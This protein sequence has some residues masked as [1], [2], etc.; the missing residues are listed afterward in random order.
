MIH[1]TQT[2]AERSPHSSDRHISPWIFR[3]LGR[4]KNRLVSEG[5]TPAI[6]LYEE[7]E[8]YCVA[9]DLA[10]MQAEQIN[11]QVE[12]NNVLMLTGQRSMP[13]RS[14]CCGQLKVHL[15]EIDYGHF[16]RAVKLPQN[17]ETEQIEASY[18][19]GYLW[20]RLPKKA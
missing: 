3:V 14:Q 13:Q 9:V 12:Q 16:S 5:W 15:M 4:E 17:V 8:A 10:G 11:L 6:N 20:I 1:A 7:Q 19:N 18:K 2:M